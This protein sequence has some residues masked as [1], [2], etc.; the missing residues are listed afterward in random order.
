MRE[1]AW[2]RDVKDDAMQLRYMS[3]AALIMFAGGDPWK[4]NATLQSGLPARISDLAQAFYDAGLSTA[5]ADAA[6]GRAQDRFQ[7]SWT[8]RGRGNPI[9]G[10]FEV[11]RA[12]RALG[13]QVV[14]L[15]R[16]GVDLEEVAAALAEAQR[17]GNDAISSLE[18]RLQNIDD[19]LGQAVELEKD[20]ALSAVERR[21]LDEHITGLEDRAIGDT[22]QSLTK[23]EG[24]RDQYSRQLHLAKVNLQKQ[25]GYDLA[26][27]EG[28]D[29]DKPET[30]QGQDERRHNQIEAFKQI[31][32]REPVAAADWETAAALD[33]HSYDPKFQGT[34]PQIEVAK[35]RTVPG[36]GLVRVSQ[37]IE[38][39]D[40]TSFPFWR[41]DLGNNRVA[42]AHFDPEDTKVA[43]YI[44]YENGLV[45]LRQNPSVEETSTGG[46]GRVK[47]GTP[48]GSV[49]QLPDGSVRI[50][51]DAG[52][53]FAPGITADPTGPFADHTITVNGDL[54]FTPGPD[55]VQV[56]GTRTDYP[57]MEVYQDLPN[58]STLTALI[59]HAKS[60]RS[61][62]PALNLSG[63]HDIG[64]LGGKAF[65]PFDT[66]AWNPT[67]DVPSGLPLTQF[68]PASN[69]PSVFALPVGEGVPA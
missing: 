27:I 22:Q 24:I 47:V 43:T 8:H 11:R 59:D 17:S 56:N 4:V 19:Q 57:S 26:P 58:G 33:P 42:N 52:N 62:G 20:P 35:I 18:G 69:P 46:P 54:V 6:F 29:G 7:R 37:W 3:Q 38:Q 41:R 67:Y 9:N 5:E 45:V 15:R 14:Q 40:V 25:D 39:R 68:G 51:Y 13:L 16:I 1:G 28:F 36:Q 10:S 48:K 60:G 44:D 50:K 63:H 32:G 31:F 23:V 21:L 12:T 49:T 30:V 2:R 64:P 53:P 34:G 66:G 65:A 61:W 55:G